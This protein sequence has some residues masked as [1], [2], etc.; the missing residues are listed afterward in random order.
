LV[1]NLLYC[2]AIKPFELAVFGKE[3]GF[4]VY[5]CWKKY[6]LHRGAGRYWLEMP[7]IH[8]GG[9]KTR[10]SLGGQKIISRQKKPFTSSPP[11]AN[12]IRIFGFCWVISDNPK[13]GSRSRRGRFTTVV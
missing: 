6:P 3:I 4:P 9:L 12:K 7:V 5:P 1:D 13:M 8:D 10:W 11:L 2:K